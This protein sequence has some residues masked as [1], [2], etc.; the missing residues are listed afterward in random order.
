MYS[1]N[2]KNIKTNKCYQVALQNPLSKIHGLMSLKKANILAI[3][4]TSAITLQEGLSGL[5][6]MLL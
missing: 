1:L 5:V 2:N 6:L 3:G 4:G